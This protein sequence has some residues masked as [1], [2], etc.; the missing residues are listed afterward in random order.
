MLTGP[1]QKW[2]IFA[3]LA[4]DVGDISPGRKNKVWI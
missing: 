3:G 1:E 4:F 2:L